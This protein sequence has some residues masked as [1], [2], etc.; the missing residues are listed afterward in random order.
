MWVVP[1]ATPVTVPSELPTVAI[2][3]LLVLHVPGPSWSV[4]TIEEP[5][6]TGTLPDIAGGIARAVIDVV[7]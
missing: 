7:A 4:R 2:V 3:G 1:P 5:A 6:H